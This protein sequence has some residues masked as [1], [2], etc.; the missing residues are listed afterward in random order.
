MA[1]AALGGVV[2]WRHVRFGHKDEEFLDVALDASAQPGWYC[3]R[4][5][6]EGLADGQQAALQCQLDNPPSL[7]LGM[8]EG[9]GRGIELVDCPGP[10]DQWGVLWVEGYQ[11]VDV[12]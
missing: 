11:V 12:P 8:V 2:V 3:R 10:L 4:V 1:Q 6:Q 5:I 9:F 7:L